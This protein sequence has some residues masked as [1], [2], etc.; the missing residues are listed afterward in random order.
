MARIYAPEQFQ[1]DAVEK[2]SAKENSALNKE[3]AD[4]RKIFFNVADEAGNLYSDAMA[5]VFQPKSL[6]QIK[7]DRDH[8]KTSLL[9][10][11]AKGRTILAKKTAGDLAPIGRLA[12]E[13]NSYAASAQQN[14]PFYKA[15]YSAEILSNKALPDVNK[16]IALA[17]PQKRAALDANLVGKT[18][19]TALTRLSEAATPLS[20]YQPE[21]LEP[22]LQPILTKISE[23]LATNISSLTAL[24]SQIEADREKALQE[25]GVKLPERAKDALSGTELKSR[26]EKCKTEKEKADLIMEQ[27]AKGNFPDNFRMFEPVNVNKNGRTAQFNV[28]RRSVVFGTKEDSIEIPVD[29][30][31]AKAIAD[32]LNCSLPSAW[33]VDEIEAEGKQNGQYARFFHQ[34]DFAQ[35]IRDSK[36]KPLDP[37]VL[38][39]DLAR[40]PSFIWKRYEKVSEWAKAHGV[41]FDKLTY[42]YFKDITL[43]EPWLTD[44]GRLEIKG[45][46]YEKGETGKPGERVQKLSEGTHAQGYYDYSHGQRLVDG[47][48]L[49]DGKPMLMADFMKDGELAKAFG[50]TARDID[51]AYP[52]NKNLQQWVRKIKG[53]SAAPSGQNAKIQILPYM[54][55]TEFQAN[56]QNI[57]IE[58]K[59]PSGSKKPATTPAK[60]LEIAASYNNTTFGSITP[61]ESEGIRYAAV[62]E[63]KYIPA[64]K[65]GVKKWTHGINIYE[66]A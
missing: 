31:T 66:T 48:V 43:P 47:I 19:D 29:G 3:L 64:D 59:L 1:I 27:V 36:G 56:M 46:F 2:K 34:G 53:A 55:P 51:T 45:G 63:W 40:S 9:D 24:R 17:N 22:R 13:I 16:A 26:Y 25:G 49:I 52:Y 7:E 12:E 37:K 28:A 44:G 50:F 41:D 33:L 32:S 61:F 15:A 5:T 18:I 6:E 30:P 35:E 4:R 38:H 58:K 20:A 39:D 65:P 42:G 21:S 57:E 62:K 60:A 11:A 23:P 8:V 14:I 10:V 54:Q